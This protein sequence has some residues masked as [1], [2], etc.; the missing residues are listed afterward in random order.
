MKNFLQI[1]KG[2]IFPIG[3]IL[4]LAFSRLIP[5]YPNFTPVIA[6]A[7]MSSYFFKNI[8]LSFVVIIFS[9]LISDVFIG[10]YN[11]IFFVYLSLLLIAFI[12]FRFNTRIKLKNLFIFSF[13]G[14]SIFF[15]ISNFGV[16]LLSNMYEKNL[17]GLIYCYFLALPFFLNTLL[18]TVFFSYL[19]FIANNFFTL[20]YKKLDL[21]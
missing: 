20:A 11:N 18:S 4:I 6:V 13:F 12:F 7:I 16:W 17:N 21:S 5:H 9:M 8:Y 10:F 14:S 2:E 1:F 15:L 19:A 3:L